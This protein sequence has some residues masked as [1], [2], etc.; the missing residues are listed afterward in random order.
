MLHS[1][2]NDKCLSARHFPTT[3]TFDAHFAEG[4]GMTG[5][6]K[7][8][9]EQLKLLGVFHYVVG[10]LSALFSC[11][12]L[13]HLSIGLFVLLRP[14]SMSGPEGDLPPE[15]IGYLFTFVGGLFFLL[16][17]AFSGS[18]IYSG[19][20]LRKQKKYLF[21]FVMGCIECIFLPFG[22]VLGIFTIIVL[23]KESVKRIY[24]PNTSDN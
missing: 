8:D 19:I 11:M 14:E 2:I 15:F 17:I 13:I 6:L 4:N 21:S 16:G 9:L 12:F 18:V 22:T 3:S 24:A 10:G 7:E 23:S 5:P 1:G 20:L